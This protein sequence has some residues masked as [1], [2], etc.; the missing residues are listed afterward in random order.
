MNQIKDQSTIKNIYQ[1][2]AD[3]QKKVQTVYKNETVKMFENDKGYKAVT[4]DDVAAALHTPL[5]ECGIFM[6]PDVLEY[7]TTTFEKENKYKTMVTWYRTDIK[8]KCKWINID[9]PEDFIESSGGAFALDTSDKSYA[10]A[11]SLALKIILLKV[12]LLESKDGEE[13]RPFDEHNNQNFKD[14]Q[15]KNQ[16]QSNNKQYAKGNGNTQSIAN[17]GPK[18]E[19]NKS[20]P[21]PQ[22]SSNT[23][24]LMSEDQSEQI[25]NLMLK[26]SLDGKDIENFFLT[27]FNVK[28]DAVSFAQADY[29]IKM[30]SVEMFSS[31]DLSLAA[32]DLKTKREARN[33]T[34]PDPADYVI[35][36][37]ILAAD[38]VFKGKKLRQI[39]EKSLKA[40]IAATDEDLKDKTNPQF[41]LIFEANFKAKS[42][43]KSVGV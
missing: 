28:S 1:R 36:D 7:Q 12:H 13:Q 6:L 17:N 20:T 2:M 26:H 42:F 14:Q 11:Y 38:S 3:V 31:L 4:H 37:R 23:P 35:D 25:A 21:G 27:G 39:D 15:N 22:T 34:Q 32:G 9:K 41:K 30:L 24:P 16:N 29:L 10:K 5:A 33:Q 40:F 8:I 18:P 43:L 19:S